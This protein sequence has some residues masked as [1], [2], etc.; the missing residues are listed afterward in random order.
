MF[1]AKG[2][3][4]ETCNH[5]RL[6]S[7]SSRQPKVVERPGMTRGGRPRSK[8]A[9]GPR[10]QRRSSKQARSL[11]QWPEGQLHEYQ[12]SA[13]PVRAFVVGPDRRESE[14][15]VQRVGLSLKISGV[16]PHGG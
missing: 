8:N 15:P 5:F 4:D 9:V 16:E 6:I 13:E 10:R 11:A 12:V 14:R 3:A 7:A 1:G 2:L